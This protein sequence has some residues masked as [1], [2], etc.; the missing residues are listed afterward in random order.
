MEQ[1]QPIAYTILG[2]GVPVLAADGTQVGT[3][4]HVV[5]AMEQDIFHGIVI[6]TQDHGRRFVEAAGVASLHEGGVDLKIDVS[7]VASLPEPPGA[8]SEYDAK[9]ATVN[10]WSHW[11]HRLTGRNDWHRES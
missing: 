3:V 10:T 11:V 1:G 4:H 7:A 8:A 2:R 5:A 9:A 6:A